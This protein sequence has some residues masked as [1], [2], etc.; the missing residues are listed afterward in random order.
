[1][2]ADGNINR[3]LFFLHGSVLDT[4]QYPESET[5]HQKRDMS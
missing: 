3:L 4:L 5:D 1:M 2:V